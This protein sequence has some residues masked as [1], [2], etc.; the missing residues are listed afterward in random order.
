[1]L[2][3][4]HE[5]NESFIVRTY[6]TPQAALIPY[7]E[8]EAFRAWRARQR[9][10]EAWVVELRAIKT[11]DDG[12]S[13]Q[14]LV[15][16]RVTTGFVQGEARLVR[17]YLYRACAGAACAKGLSCGCP[18][19]DGSSCALPACVDERVDPAEFIENPSALPPNPFIPIA[20][21]CGTERRACGDEC[22]DTGSDP[23]HCGDC[24]VS[25]PRGTVCDGGAC[26]NP[27]DCR[28]D[29]VECTGFSYCDATTGDCLRGCD[30]DEQCAGGNEACDIAMHQCVCAA[31]FERCAF[32]CIDLQTDPRFCGNCE[33]SCPPGF[34]CE[35]GLCSDLGDCRANGVGCSGF[36]FCDE[37]T[38]DCLPGC[39]DDDQCPGDGEVCDLDT[40]ECICDEGFELCSE[41][42]CPT[43]CP[44]GEVELDDV[45][46]AVHVRTIDGSGSVGLHTSIALDLTGAPRISYYASTRDDLKVAARQDD[47]V[48]VATIADS[49]GDVGRYSSLALD[50]G[51]L[52]HIAYY[53]ASGNQLLHATQRT[54]GSWDSEVVDSDG[55]VG[56]HA[57]LALDRNDVAHVSYYDD[58]DNRLRYAVRRGDGSWEVDVVDQEE[59]RGKFTSLAVDGSGF[60]HI[61]YYDNGDERLRYAAQKANRDWSV[62]PVASDEEVGEY[63]SLA[64][65]AKGTPYVSYYDAGSKDLVVAR[66][67]PSGSWSTETVDFEGNVGKY[68]S[69][70]FGI[71]GLAR[72][73]YYDQSNRALK[74]AIQVRGG[75][76]NTR[77]VDDDGRVG[78]YTS[79]AVD[80][81]G[82]SHVSYY[83]ETRRDL[84]YAFIAAPE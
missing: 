4:V 65:D 24:F 37:A 21:D 84:K 41:G 30:Q 59:D 73:S 9:E 19:E 51:G 5:G 64:F 11:G 7:K 31:G 23:S 27:G 67:S 66:R 77:T 46:A 20:T 62:E 83:D 10:R 74:H 29:D 48:W 81:Q 12:Q 34:A 70:A 13:E 42:C 28:R 38:G 25:C 52:A 72:I 60:V 47:G 16:R 45:C 82:H 78:R 8:F 6:G 15:S 22:I 69:I 76:W 44:P 53:D 49:G 61:S 80:A 63:T 35:G 68:T 75:G 26:A 55:N 43:G 58:S 40:H 50:R 14:T 2:D 33:T 54:D 56:K 32:D 39:G 79:I 18:D 57:S 71:D 17:V 3:Q 36:T 1:M